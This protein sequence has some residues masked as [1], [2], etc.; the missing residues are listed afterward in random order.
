MSGQPRFP[1]LVIRASA[2]T[3]KTHQLATRFIGLLAAGAR[4]DQIL[5]TTFTRK[6]AGE[7]LDRVLSRLAAAADDD[8]H[9]QQLA[10]DIGRSLARDDCR[11]LLVTTV[12][13]LHR[14]HVGT[15]D[16][17]FIRVATQFGPELGLPPG[18]AI[19][20]ELIDAVLRDEAV[21][22]LLATGRSADLLALVHALAKG[23]TQRSVSRLVHDTVAGL[24][25]VFRD[26]QPVAWDAL[27][28]PPALRPEELVQAL[29]ALAEL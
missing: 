22:Q 21:E 20:D 15:L 29:A 26:A 16:G 1:H 13:Q 27:Q 8:A 28:Y 17:Y 6:A 4:P 11:A 25:D 5:A 9:R 2:G 3:G 14:L 18:W 24:F 19:G 12:R 10:Q 7:I 23:A